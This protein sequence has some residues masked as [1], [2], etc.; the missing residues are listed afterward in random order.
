MSI[1]ASA[2]CNPRRR[3][4]RAPGFTIV[5]V[6]VV[7]VVLAV[8]AGA[9]VPRLTS[10]AGRRARVEAQALASTL[11]AA[12]MRD[13]VSSQRV[14]LDFDGATLRAMAYGSIDEDPDTARL[15]RPDP[16]IPEA[17]LRELSLAA[18][19]TDLARLSGETFR[20]EFPR[21]GRRPAIELHL[22]DSRGVA[23]QVS[24]AS[25]ATRALAGS[26][27]EQVADAGVVD[28][29]ASG[30]GRHPW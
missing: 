5:E 23:W 10:S 21:M 28:L 7:M 26:Q 22:V 15:W 30:Q 13:A 25:G 11:S 18:V 4:L 27:L 6:I 9:I 20:I 8:L 19:Q 2:C 14:A 1:V 3:A 17:R 12:A 24:L 29:D 16:L